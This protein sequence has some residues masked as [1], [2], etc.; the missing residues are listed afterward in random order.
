MSEN[1]D[2]VSL[3]QPPRVTVVI[4]TFRRPLQLAKCISSCLNQ[5]HIEPSSFE[6]LVVDNSPERSAEIA[7]REFLDGAMTSVRYVHEPNSGISHARN[8][9]LSNANSEFVAFIDDDEIVSDTWLAQMLVTQATCN[10]EVVFGPVLPMIEASEN[11][12]CRSFT[13]DLL[14]HSSEHLTGTVVASKLLVPFWARDG[15]AF[16]RLAS[17]NVLIWHQS[18]KVNGLRFEPDLGRTGGE[19]DLYFNQL[20]S[21]GARMVWCAEAVAWEH[22]P[23]DRLS[24]RYAII[25]AFAGGQGVSRIPLLLKPR[26]PALTVLSMTIGVVQVP[27]YSALVAINTLIGSQRRHHYVVRLAGAFGKLFWASPFRRARYGTSE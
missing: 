11:A 9:G 7:V 1:S 3:P 25:R 18:P 26:R 17:G 23:P 14:T 12:S 24:L 15:R 10:A 20:A 22:L 2:C 21:S 5:I 6:I 19:D 8:A 16:I 13:R 27:T 4:P